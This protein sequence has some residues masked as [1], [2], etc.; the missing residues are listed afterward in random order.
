[1]RRSGYAFQIYVRM[2]ICTKEQHHTFTVAYLCSALE[3]FTQEELWHRYLYSVLER[4]TH[5]GISL[6]CVGKMYV[7]TINVPVVF[8]TRYVMVLRSAASL[9]G[10]LEGV[11]PEMA[12][13][14]RVPFGPKKVECKRHKNNW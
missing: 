12:R 11:G 6:Q 2:Y 4:C 1:M 9:R 5:C 8:M 3:T 13:A 10:A 7:I 14:R